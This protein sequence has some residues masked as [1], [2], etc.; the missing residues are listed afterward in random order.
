MPARSFFRHF[1]ACGAIS[2][3]SQQV[4]N[5]RRQVVPHKPRCPVKLALDNPR[6]C[7]IC[8]WPW[9]DDVECK[10]VQYNMR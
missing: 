10:C 3:T 6:V 1:C 5:H 2:F 9:G 7:G 8:G 4:P